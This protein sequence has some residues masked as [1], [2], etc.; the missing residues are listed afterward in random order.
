MVVSDL[1]GHWKVWGLV[2]SPG[3]TWSPGPGRWAP[4]RTAGP[5]APCYGSGPSNRSPWTWN[6]AAASGSSRSRSTLE[7]PTLPRWKAVLWASLQHVGNL[8]RQ[9]QQLSTR[10]QTGTWNNWKIISVRGSPFNSPLFLFILT[11]NKLK[12]CFATINAQKKNFTPSS[13][14]GVISILSKVK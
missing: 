10:E 9:Q 1:S 6:W 5:A 13:T 7:R 14:E 12:L 4:H 3:S 2:D 11:S 8:R